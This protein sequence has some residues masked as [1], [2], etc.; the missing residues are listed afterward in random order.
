[1]PVCALSD[2]GQANALIRILVIAME[3]LK[4][5]GVS[6][7]LSS[8]VDL[9]SAEDHDGKRTLKTVDGR[10]IGAEL[11]VRTPDYCYPLW[12]FN[13][14]SAHVHR[15]TAQHVLVEKCLGFFY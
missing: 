3:G 13:P 8:R 6:V 1:M 5:L 7:L 11:V 12:R 2:H 4:E 14:V 15:T 10:R 9:N